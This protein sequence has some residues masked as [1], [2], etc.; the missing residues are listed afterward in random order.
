METVMLSVR[1]VEPRNSL[2]ELG[3]T[4]LVVPQYYGLSNVIDGSVLSISN[5]S[6]VACT[7]R[8]MTS[9]TSVPSLG[10]LVTEG[11]SGQRKGKPCVYGS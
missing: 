8:L 1:V 2:M 10:Q 6:D 5:P 11:D 7:I 3:S 9:E 4:P